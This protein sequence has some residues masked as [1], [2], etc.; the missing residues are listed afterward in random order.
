[1]V[2]DTENLVLE[3]LRAVRSEVSSLRKELRRDMRDVR[4]RLSGIESHMVDRI[5]S[6]RHSASL[7]ELNERV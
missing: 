4:M 1:M 2:D 5:E 3:M 6:G 7:Y